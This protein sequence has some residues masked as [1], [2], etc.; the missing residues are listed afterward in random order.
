MS[1]IYDIGY[2][3]YDGPRL[4]RGHST[5]A[6]AV[7]SLRG[8]FGLGRPARSK[9]VPFALVGIM[10]IPSIVSIAIMALAQQRGIPY[11]G[12]AVVMQAVV[13]IFLAAQAPAV[14]APDL[15]Y[16]VLPLYLSRPVSIAEYVGAKVTAMTVA[17][18][19]LIAGPLTLAYVGELVVDM[20]GPP[21]TGEYL[22]AM[23]MALVLS[24]LL[25]AFGL[26]LASFTP[27]RGLGVASVIT[28]Y[29]L[30]SASVPVIYATFAETGNVETAKWA[31]LAN[32]F[33]LVD[34]VQ[35]WLFGTPPHSIEGDYPSGPVS[36]LLLV[37]LLAVAM[38]A[39]ALRYRKAAAR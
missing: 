15:R 27:R 33:W 12:F 20:P 34:S 10:F 25:S 28:V 30:S 9:I 22:G 35:H 37:V 3:H 1:E 24:L 16:R 17:V 2:R 36:A 6:L 4:G 8:V 18:F 5:R 7:H 13:A 32:P 23:L 26:A 39:L 11:S 29:L 31:W 19:A 21:A 38:L 14:V